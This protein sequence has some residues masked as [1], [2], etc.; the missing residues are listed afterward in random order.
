MI[1]NLFVE[2][3]N[4]K[5]DRDLIYMK[6]LNFAL[7]RILEWYWE[8]GKTILDVTAGQQRSWSPN[9]ETTSLLTGEKSWDV[10]FLDQSPDAKLQV[11]A[12]FRHLPF[13]DNSFDIIYFDPPF[14]KPANGV[15][16]FGIKTH[17]TPDRLYY[18]RQIDDKW[19]PPEDFFQQTWKEFN[20]VSKNGLVV[21]ISERYEQGYE[22]PVTTYMD[23]CYDKRLNPVSDFQRCARVGYRG[24]RAGLGAKMIH[25]QRVLSYYTVYKKDYKLH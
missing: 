17:K 5:P 13:A 12:D 20:R 10:T 8:A 3:G 23:V 15:E 25:P 11:M 2:K 21:K 9:I 1:T 4:T 16:A 19:V 22:I 6:P 18:F 24:K 14:M 7:K